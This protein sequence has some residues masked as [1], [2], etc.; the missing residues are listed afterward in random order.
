MKAFLYPCFKGLL[1]FFFLLVFQFQLEARH[2]FVPAKDSTSFKEFKGSVLDEKTKKELAFAS[3]QISGTT[4]ATISNSEGEFSIK[5]PQDFLHSN[6]IISFLGYD[7]RVVPIDDLNPEKN[8]IFLNPGTILL[9]EVVVEIRDAKNIFL[10]VMKNRKQNYGDNPIQMT[11]FYR[12]TIRKRR[13]YVSLSESVIEIQKQPFSINR[14]DE[15]N[16]F[17]GR[18]NADY[19]KL[20]TLN[21]KLQGGPF[22]ALYVDL[23][24]YSDFIFSDEVFDFYEF[25]LDEITQINDQKVLVVAFKQKNFLSDPLYY[26]KLYIDAKSFAIISANFH[27]NVEDRVKSGLLFTRKKPFGVVVYPTEVSYQI[28][29][30]KQND[31][32]VFAYSRGD[33]SFKLNWDKKLFNTV[34]HTTQELA[35][36]YWKNQAIGQSIPKENLRSNVI[37]SEKVSSYADPSF[38]GEYNIIEPEKSIES[39]IRKIQSLKD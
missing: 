26:G 21:F 34:Y 32:W 30:R 8:T 24:K 22:S 3:I 18:K 39:A 28:N 9:E 37:M 27:L 11:G 36:T 31:Q 15:V 17:K 38:W 35:V 12:E 4:I 10:E 16:L 29:Y 6:L 13:N 25:T 33:L 2:S 7:S 14:K 23:V 19:S 20:D 1:S 5:I